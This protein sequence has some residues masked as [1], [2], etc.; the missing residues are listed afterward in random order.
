MKHLHSI[1]ISLFATLFCVA[2]LSC[3]RRGD[4]PPPVQRENT[5]VLMYIVA[6]NNLSSS[7]VSDMEE[8]VTSIPADFNAEDN[9]MIYID[10]RDTTLLYKVV[11][12]NGVGKKEAVKGYSKRNS[13]DKKNMAQVMEDVKRVAPADHYGIILSSHATGW[14]PPAANSIS[15]QRAPMQYPEISW[16]KAEGAEL[17]RAF[18]DDAGQYMSI[19]D[20]AEGLSPINFDFLMFDACFMASVEALYDLRNSARYIIASP[21]EIMSDGFPYFKVAPMFFDRSDASLESVC[22]TFIDF[23]NTSARTKSAAITLIDCSKID[24]LAQSVKNLFAAGVNEADVTEIQGLEG[25]RV[26]AF[27]DMADYMAAV[28]KDEGL[29]ATFVTALKAATIYT[30]HTDRIYSA[31]NA[32]YFNLNVPLC[33][34]TCFI[35]RATLPVNTGYYMQTAWA[36]YIYSQ[37]E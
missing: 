10:K 1:K 6:A 30:G 22:S 33:G 25:M 11:I 34:W 8:V 17:T 19:P 14:F 29:H 5:T 28:S 27:Y 13:L 9:M 16:E 32:G 2:L 36:K 18:G 3:C 7:L 31:Y 21:A 26:H 35:P 23:Y 37:A 4:T 20:L 15:S 24:A 12:E